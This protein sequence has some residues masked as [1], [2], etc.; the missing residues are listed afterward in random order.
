[1]TGPKKTNQKVENKNCHRKNLK[2]R[3][4]NR[5]WDRLDV[6]VHT[7]EDWYDLKENLILSHL[8]KS[9][10]TR[11]QETGHFWLTSRWKRQ[12]Q[13][14]LMPFLRWQGPRWKCDSWNWT[15]LTFLRQQAANEN[16]AA[17]SWIFFEFFLRQVQMKMWRSHA[18]CSTFFAAAGS[19]MKLQKIVG[20]LTFGAAGI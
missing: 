13:A 11:F 10:S 8:H 7:K 15:V 2:S 20:K 9:S 17:P 19:Q 18:G 3:L 6:F 12:L 5:R 4:R 14:G 16:V 1:M